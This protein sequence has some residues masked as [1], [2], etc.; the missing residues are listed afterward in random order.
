MTRILGIDPGSRITGFGLIDLE[1]SR[2]RYVDAGCIKTSGD[3]LAGRLKTIFEGL[4]AVIEAHSPDEVAVEQV[5]MHRNASAALKLGQARGAA[6]VAAVTHSLEVYEYMPKTIK[7]AVTGRGAASKEQVQH[8]VTI[9]LSLRET[10]ATDAADALAV[11]LC[12]GHT[13]QTTTRLA[14]AQAATRRPAP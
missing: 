10:P 3:D 7:Q 9:M 6:L 4:S 8:M 5:F 13:Q 11:A 2:T 14:A 1:R 12:H